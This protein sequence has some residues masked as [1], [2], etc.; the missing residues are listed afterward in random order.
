MSLDLPSASSVSLLARRFALLA[1][2]SHSILCV[3]AQSGSG[4]ARDPGVRPGVPSAGGPVAGLTAA[5]SAAFN[6]GQLKFNAVDSVSGKIS[7]EPDAGLGP[8]FNMNSCGGC[9][10][11]PSV[12]G[13]SPRINPQIAVATL[14]GARN[15][16]PSFLAIDGPVREARFQR[17]ADG[18]PDGGVHDLF[19]ITGRTDAPGC[20]KPQTNFAAQ[21][22]NGNVVFRIPTPIYGG[23]LIESIPDGAIL[24]NMAANSALK[25]QLG[26][27][28]HVNTNGNDG[29]ITRFGWKAQNKSLL[30]F[31]GEAYAVE[32]GVTNELFPNEREF[33][34][35]CQGLG[36]PED[37]PDFAAGGETDIGL[38]AVFMRFLAP[39]NPVPSYAG[40]PAASISR[41]HAVF[42][43]TGCA[44]CH[45]ESFKTGPA[46]IPSLA[47][48]PVAL[49]SDLLVHNM[50]TG[51]ADGI[52]QGSA[53]TA[54]FRT[55]PL[56]GLG[57]RYFFL[58][59]GRSRDLTDTIQAHASTGSE[60]NGVVNT[61]KALPDNARQDLLN[62]LRS[63]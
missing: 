55:A 5:Q 51:L 58:H 25:N 31:A 27:R 50:G 41:G 4:S 35:T 54:E 62:F 56:W 37:L 18:T 36:S 63:L 52:S 44:L 60:A 30:L 38:F 47:N 2:V 15:T 23:G 6:N 12:G 3:S 59:D 1:L 45:T 14:H 26:I 7:G 17:N 16:V 34:S 22:A 24:A 33:D 19:V 11:F 42:V 28:G 10:N 61:Y 48:Q 40:V 20:G 49:F 53:G 29:T 57:Q 32:Q 43:S 46:S 13:S 8:G 21:L 39:P 9:H